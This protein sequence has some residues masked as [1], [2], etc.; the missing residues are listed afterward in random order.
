[1]TPA[2][3]FVAASRSAG[4]DGGGDLR[5]VYARRIAQNTGNVKS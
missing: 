3:A 2:L 4:G 5:R 1:L